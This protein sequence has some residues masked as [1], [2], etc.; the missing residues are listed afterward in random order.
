MY[1]FGHFALENFLNK[2]MFSFRYL[3]ER[4]KQLQEEVTMLKTNVM[5]YKVL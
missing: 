4:F 3:H 1:D 5:K 2:L